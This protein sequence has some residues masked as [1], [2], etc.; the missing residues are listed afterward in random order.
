MNISIGNETNSIFK[1]GKPAFLQNE[2]ISTGNP[3]TQNEV[4]K[5]LAD[6]INGKLDQASISD[7]AKQL[8][9]KLNEEKEV[10]I[11]DAQ[12][13]LEIRSFLGSA[14]QSLQNFSEEIDMYLE[15]V[16]VLESETASAEQKSNARKRL[17]SIESVANLHGIFSEKLLNMMVPNASKFVNAA[18]EIAKGFSKDVQDL[19][20]NGEKLLVTNAKT[21]GL[22]GITEKSTTEMRDILT[23]AKEKVLQKAAAIEAVS[24]SISQVNSKI[25]LQKKDL[26]TETVDKSIAD[27]ISKAIE[28]YG[29]EFLLNPD[30]KDVDF[31]APTED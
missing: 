27:I 22:E 10:E 12:T 2:A 18:Y 30:R 25:E 3:F 15:N 4:T 11:S 29:L 20:A 31:Q 23:E 7:E 17:N 14:K 9:S 5:K 26:S 24:T 13:K 28:Q 19:E 16:N 1:N 21:L 6:L 8:L